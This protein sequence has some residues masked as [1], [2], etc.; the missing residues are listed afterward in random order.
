MSSEAAIQRLQEVTV[1][2]LQFGD[3][4]RIGIGVWHFLAISGLLLQTDCKEALKQEREEQEARMS[5]PLSLRLSKRY[6]DCQLWKKSSKKSFYR[7]TFIMPFLSSQLLYWISNVANVLF[8]PFLLL[9]QSEAY[10]KYSYI[11][12]VS[13]T[14]RVIFLLLLKGYSSYTM[15]SWEHYS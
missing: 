13:V 14:W 10:P 5:M 2:Q 1:L 8:A 9:F 4:S 15:C 6:R 12:R 3:R 7:S 11:Q